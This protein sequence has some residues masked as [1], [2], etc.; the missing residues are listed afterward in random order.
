MW[1]NAELNAS[2]AFVAAWLPGTEGAGIADVIF[3][4]PA[5]ATHHDFVGKL[6][7]SWPN[8]ADQLVLNR[9]DTDYDPLFA[10][11]FGLTYQD[12]D[13]LGDN[14]D[15]SNSSSGQADTLFSVPGIIEAEL[16]ASMNGIQTEASTDSGGGTG[17]G[18]NIGYVDTGDWLQYN[19]DVQTPGS[20]LIEYR[21]ASDLGSSGFATLI[22]GTEIDRQSVPNTGG[23]QNWTTL[24]AT[25]DL[26]A[27]EQVLRINALGPSWNMNWIRLSVSN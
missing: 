2:N 10:Y 22:N 13:T 27:G 9:N 6:S 3:Q 24:S 20:Y 7:F 1:V 15:I 21:L 18:R 12:T 14:L 5:G 11:G 19:I 16:Y 4:T 17:G 25:V 8:S 23:W 26:Q